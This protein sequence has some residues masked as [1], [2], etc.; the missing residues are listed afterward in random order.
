MLD[1]SVI[2]IGIAPIGWT[3]DDMPELGGEISF[4]QCIT[5]MQQ[6]GY[7]G[8]EVGSKFPKDPETL[9]KALEPVN[10]QIAAQWFSA[11][12]T[13][14]TDPTETI[15]AFKKHLAFLKAMG[16]KIAVISEQGNSIQGQMNT[17]IFGNK[18]ILDED[19]WNKLVSGL[20]TIGKIAIENDMKIA[21]HHHMG[22]VV[23][24]LDEVSILMKK[25]DPKFVFLL[26]DTGHI[27]YSG[28]N[29]V[30][31]FS[32]FIG[33]I[34][35]IHLKDVRQDVLDKVKNS[36]LSFL[37]GVKEGAFT[38]PGDGVIDYKPIFEI[39]KNSEYKGWLLVEAEQDPVKA[40]PLEYAK[41]GRETIKNLTGI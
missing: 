2:K 14:E 13:T 23:Q 17:P 11:F 22:T 6:A 27:Y 4:E 26:G 37:Q 25:T 12:F 39:I 19:G 20:N 7:E 18:P 21:Y 24:T 9:K 10:L 38:V 16:A 31:L 28:D 32:K 35:H 8:C 30:D 34:V 40:N 15:E 1:K 29:P 36:N 41:K 5:E 3:N 33:R